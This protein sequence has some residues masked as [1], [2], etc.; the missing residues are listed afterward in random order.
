MTKNRSLPK[1]SK[2]HI[3]NVINISGSESETAFENEDLC[4][5]IK[6]IF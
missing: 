3:Q 4:C 6:Q 2:Q 5:L 1:L